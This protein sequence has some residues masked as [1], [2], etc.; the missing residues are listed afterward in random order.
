ME[1][2][3]NQDPDVRIGRPPKSPESRLKRASIRLPQ[4]VIDEINQQGIGRRDAPDFS[5]L[6]RELIAEALE[7]RAKQKKQK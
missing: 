5:A 1:C 4:S 3:S 2:M 6:V 7:A